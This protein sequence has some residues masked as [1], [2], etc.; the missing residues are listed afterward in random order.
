MTTYAIGDGKLL[1][2]V[3]A[4]LDYENNYPS[5]QLISNSAK[6]RWEKIAEEYASKLGDDNSESESD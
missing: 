4:E 1:Y 2:E 3:F 5:Y 6:A